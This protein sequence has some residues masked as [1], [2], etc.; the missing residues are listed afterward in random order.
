MSI[1]R[2]PQH[3]LDF[4]K[5]ELDCEGNFGS[6]GNLI[7]QAKFQNKHVT[8]QYRKYLLLYVKCLDCKSLNTVI[9]K[10]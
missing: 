3:I 4:Y 8:N 6:E 10:D 2:E 1:N 5:A 7:F 9:S